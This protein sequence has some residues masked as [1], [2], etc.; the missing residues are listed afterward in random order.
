MNVSPRRL[1]LLQN[2]D[3]VTAWPGGD[4]TRRTLGREWRVYA[5]MQWL[6]KA[7]LVERN[8]DDDDLDLQGFRATEAGL[9]VLAVNA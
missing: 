9:A 3:E 2:L 7:G 4:I 1:D 8:P 6:L 5:N